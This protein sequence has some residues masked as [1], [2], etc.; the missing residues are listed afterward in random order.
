MIAT[1][2][3]VN[4]I[5]FSPNEDLLFKGALSTDNRDNIGLLPKFLNPGIKQIT[6]P[7][8]VKMRRKPVGEISNL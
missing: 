6:L 5:Y 4:R 2:V 3:N 8:G 1:V 7:L